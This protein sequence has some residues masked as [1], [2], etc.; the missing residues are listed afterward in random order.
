MVFIFVIGYVY[1]WRK[2]AGMGW[3]A[4]DRMM[5][6]SRRS[7][8]LGCRLPSRGAGSSDTPTAS[9]KPDAP[10]DGR[11]TQVLKTRLGALAD[12]FDAAYVT[13]RWRKP[14]AFIKARRPYPAPSVTSGWRLDR[15]SYRPLGSRHCRHLRTRRPQAHSTVRKADRTDWPPRAE[16]FDVVYCVLLDPPA[17]RAREQVR[18]DGAGVTP[19]RRSTPNPGR[20]QTGSS[21]RSTTCSA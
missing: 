21:A 11:W 19:C 20:R 10:G 12:H 13:R 7:G 2:G 6:D 15:R 18:T 5:A 17:A 4:D 3:M 1:A 9:P 14:P 16:R 8:A